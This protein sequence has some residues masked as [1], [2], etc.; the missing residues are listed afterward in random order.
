MQAITNKTC[1]Y[2]GFKIGNGGVSERSGLLWLEST[3]RHISNIDL[4]QKHPIN[5]N[6]NVP[7][8]STNSIKS[9]TEKSHELHK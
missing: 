3:S 2:S 7:N 1:Q 4:T 9:L 6:I 8:K 5:R